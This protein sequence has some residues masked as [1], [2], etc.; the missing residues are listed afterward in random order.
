MTTHLEQRHEV[1]IIRATHVPPQALGLVLATLETLQ[2]KRSLHQLR[3]WLSPDA[4]VSLAT[5]VESG[6]F[7]RSQVGRIRVQMPT[8]T[9][10]EATARISVGPRW[11]ACVVR[12]DHRNRWGCS[13]LAVLTVSS[14]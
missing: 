1:R 10:I 13:E 5:Q 11:L 12:L 4:F 2:G 3:P 6:A 14:V 8:P 9:A 7:S